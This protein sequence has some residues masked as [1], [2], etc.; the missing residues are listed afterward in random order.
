M[1]VEVEDDVIG[2][3]EQVGIGP[4]FSDTPGQVR[5]TAPSPGKHTEEVLEDLG[6][7]SSKIT[8][9]RDQ[10]IVA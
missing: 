2:T 10:G 9:L 4:K 8:S 1:M 7:D 6:Y 5:T 3:V